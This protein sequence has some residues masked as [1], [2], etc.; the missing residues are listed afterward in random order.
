MFEKDLPGGNTTGFG[1]ASVST[2]PLETCET[3][4]DAWGFNI[5]DRNYKSLKSLIQ[6]LV[7]D[8][9]YGANLL[10]N[11]GPMPNGDIQPEFVDRL[12]GMGE[13]LTT[14]GPTIYGTHAGYMRPADWG[15]VTEKGNIVYLHLFKTDGDKFFV[16]VPYQ[17]KSAKLF[18]G[19][20][21]LKMQT[22]ADNYVMIDLKSIKADPIDTVVELEVAK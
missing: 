15:A 11:I 22:L 7:N 3:I 21:P 17:V 9:G 4:N 16:K 10:L 6:L 12:S 18:K 5:T 8:A 2:L 1:G 19:N 20:V 13:W 14:Y